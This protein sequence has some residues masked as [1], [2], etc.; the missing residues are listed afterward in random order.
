MADLAQ[1]ETAL[2][3]ADAARDVD[4]ARTLAGE[5]MRMRAPQGNAITDIG[6]EI[7][8]AATENIDAIKGMFGGTAD[9]GVVQQTLDVG[10]GLLGFPGLLASPITGVARSV[11][12]HLMADATRLAGQVINPQVAAREDPREVYDAS[13]GG[14]DTAMMAL[15]P[16]GVTPRGVTPVAPSAAELKTAATNVYQSPAIKSIQIAPNDV[17]NLTGG[18]QNELAQRGFRPTTGSAPGTFSEISRMTPDPSITAVGV[19]DLRAAR[20][21]FG[22]TAKQLG[23]DFKPTPDAAAAKTAIGKIDDF[24]DN[25]APELKEANANYGAS[26]QADALDYRT[27]TADHRAARTGSGSNMENA[28]RQEVDKL[29]TRG[30]TPDQAT[31]RNTIVEGSVG[32]NALRKVGKL[33]VGDGLSLMLHAGAGIGSGGA[34]LPIAAAGTAARKIGELLTR[35]QISALNTSIRSNTPL[36]QALASQP[37]LAKLPQGTKAIIAALLSQSVDRPVLPAVMPSYA[38]QN[39]R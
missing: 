18:I 32:R 8:A 19:D 1:L 33:G 35:K 20:R 5:I 37:Q 30:L 3:N 39:Q 12:G 31:L 10:K 34:T 4:A 13:K 14:V 7:K 26:K 21:A 28:L 36:A 29:P 23:P 16:R 22:Q 2:R 38:D 24:L 17:V 6:P 11:G 9:K 25:L 27:M 15:A